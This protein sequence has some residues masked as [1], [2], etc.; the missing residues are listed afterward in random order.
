MPDSE[1]RLLF[2]LKLKATV[3]RPH[4]PLCPAQYSCLQIGSFSLPLH[5]LISALCLCR[6]I[7]LAS[8]CCSRLWLRDCK[9]ATLP[10]ASWSLV[11]TSPGNLLASQT[12][13]CGVLLSSAHVTYVVTGSMMLDFWLCCRLYL[14]FF[15]KKMDGKLVYVRKLASRL[16]SSCCCAMN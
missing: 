6:S 10:S 3:C 4:H 1:L 13:D 8:T 15:Q 5:G 11:P 16:F 12:L 14:R 2:V 7:C 9:E